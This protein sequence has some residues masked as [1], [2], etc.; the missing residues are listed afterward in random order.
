MFIYYYMKYTQMSDVQ[1]IRSLEKA[2]S[3]TK[4]LWIS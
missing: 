3:N 4:Y 2:Y 1:L